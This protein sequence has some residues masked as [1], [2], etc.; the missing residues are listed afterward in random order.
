MSLYNIC[1][2]PILVHGILKVLFSTTMWLVE[3]HLLWILFHCYVR[4]FVF[5][6]CTSVINLNAFF[7]V[8]VYVL[9]G[10]SQL[11][12]GIFLDWT[13]SILLLY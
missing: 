12:P 6:N 10:I 13:S 2:V 7:T 1:L 9:C 11:Y 3:H 5:G 4:Y 8:L